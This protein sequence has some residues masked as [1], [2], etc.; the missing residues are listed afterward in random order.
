ME[1]HISMFWDVF[2][3]VLGALLTV[4]GLVFMFFIN[5]VAQSFKGLVTRVDTISNDIT[6]VKVFMKEHTLKADDYSKK[7]DQN[8]HEIKE[9]EERVRTL[10]S[11]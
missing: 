4:M 3:I 7:A 5:Q 1:Q 11:A 6:E 9:L 2:K 10:E 8:A